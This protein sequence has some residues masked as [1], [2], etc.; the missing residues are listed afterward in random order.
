MS[1]SQNHLVDFKER[2]SNST[3]Q[4]LYPEMLVVTRV[5]R[6]TTEDWIASWSS[7]EA[8]VQFGMKGKVKC[9]ICLSHT[10]GQLNWSNKLKIREK[11]SFL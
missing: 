2:N 10:N 8:G 9:E 11:D 1:A 5:T 4:V 6:V 7:L 3:F